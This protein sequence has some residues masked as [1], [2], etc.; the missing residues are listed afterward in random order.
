MTLEEMYKNIQIDPYEPYIVTLK[1]KYD[2]EENY[3]IENQYLD[4]DFDIKQNIAYPYVWLNDWYE[5]QQD[6]QVIGYIKLSEVK[7]INI[8]GD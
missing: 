7:T 8:G 3:T 2:F 6:I 4:I 5:G 1:Y